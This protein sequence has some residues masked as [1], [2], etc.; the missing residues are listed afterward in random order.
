[1][2]NVAIDI[3]K[4]SFDAGVDTGGKRKR[5][6]FKNTHSGMNDLHK[7]LKKLGVEEVHMFMEATGRY[8]EQLAIWSYGLGW[9][10]ALINPF[11]M[12]RFAESEGI[13]NKTD[14]IDADCILDFSHSAA[15]HA[16]RLWKPKSNAENALKEIHMELLGIEKIIGQE[17]NRS[18]SCITTGLIKLCIRQNIEHLK[19]QKVKLVHAALELIKSDAKLHHAYKILV[20]IKGIGD[21]TAIKML[22]RVDFDAFTKGRQLVG[23]AG[24]APKKWESGKSVRKKEIISRVGHADLRSTMYFPAVVAMTHDSEMIEYKKHLEL[25]GKPKKVIICAIMAK[26]LRK[27]F[28]LIRDSKRQQGLL[29]A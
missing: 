11:R 23:F 28:A 1:M 24:L 5:A 15:A 17:R 2:T 6:R 20:K 22:A 9:K 13:Y 8:G 7:W 12:R 10:V 26:L 16:M 14:R 19:T 29:A 18:K 3:G 25:Q 27:A 21:I 4:E